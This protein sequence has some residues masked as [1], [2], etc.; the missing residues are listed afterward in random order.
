MKKIIFGIFMLVAMVF[1]LSACSGKKAY[2]FINKESEIR[3]IEIVK[4]CEYD[5]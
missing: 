2:E 3:T 5:H 1:T 4:L